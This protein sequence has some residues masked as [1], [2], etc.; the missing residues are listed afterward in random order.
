M[1]ELKFKKQQWLEELSSS[2]LKKKV[3][4]N[5]VL[6]MAVVIFYFIASGLSVLYGYSIDPILSLVAFSIAC[7]ILSLM[8]VCLFLYTRLLM[9]LKYYVEEED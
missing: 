7:G 3:K 6:T 1:L 9:F 4:R 2:E 8:L 5:N